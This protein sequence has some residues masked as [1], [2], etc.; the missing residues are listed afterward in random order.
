MDLVFRWWTSNPK[1]LVSNMSLV[2][3]RA[4]C[5]DGPFIQEVYEEVWAMWQYRD[6]KVMGYGIFVRS[7]ELR[8]RALEL[9]RNWEL[10]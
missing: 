8:D 1:N 7:L 5:W 4:M 6:P 9:K 10:L 2:V 3:T